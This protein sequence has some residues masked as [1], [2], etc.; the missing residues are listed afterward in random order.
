MCFPA[1]FRSEK[2]TK[3]DKETYVYEFVCA[4]VEAEKSHNLSPT[5]GVPQNAGR[6]I[7]SKSKDPTK[8]TGTESRQDLKSPRT[9]VPHEMG[10]DVL[11]QQLVRGRQSLFLYLFKRFSYVCPHWRIHVLF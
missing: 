5:A 1:F 6:E 8:R 4:I 3:L 10:A 7:Q 2:K 11:F 9:G